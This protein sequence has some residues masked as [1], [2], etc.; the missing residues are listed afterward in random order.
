MGRHS[1]FL[2]ENGRLSTSPNE[3]E[4][5][6]VPQDH[7]DDVYGSG[8]SAA[9][10]LLL[11]VGTATG[12]PRYTS[13]ADRVLRYIGSGVQKN[14][15][16]WGTLVAA[17]NHH[18]VVAASPAGPAGPTPAMPGT[19]DRVRVTAAT[20]ATGGHDEIVTTLT[21]DPGWHVNANPASFDYLIPTSVSFEGLS[22]SGFVYPPAVRIKSKFAPDGLDV[23]E[24]ETRVVALFPKGALKDAAS[25]RGTLTVQACSDEVCLPPA[26]IPVTPK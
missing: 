3:N 23:Y 22:A 13:L 5:L 4:L 26:E 24:G 25:I 7:G 21:I 18:Q 19:A 17:V 15:D 20:R 9:I 16:S 2:H 1:Y 12:T 10:D 6:I 11:R 14:P 8:T